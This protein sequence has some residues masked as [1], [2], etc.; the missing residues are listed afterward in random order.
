MPI[1]MKYG[2]VEGDVQQPAHRRWI[3]LWSVQMGTY[4]SGGGGTHRGTGSANLTE[5][6]VTKG[7]DAASSGLYREALTGQGVTA[8]IDYV[9]SDGDVYLRVEMKETL[10]SSYSIS[11]SGD[12]STESL[13][14]N[15]TK[16]FFT[17]RPG[18]PPP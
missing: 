14:L 6:S 13:T 9:D 1:Y 8:W 17:S 2:S 10:V 7:L 15:F 16:V 18:T 12:R 3:E 4:R 5:I 11:G